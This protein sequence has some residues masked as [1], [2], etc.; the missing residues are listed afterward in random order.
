MTYVLF[1]PKRLLEYLHVCICHW[2]Q[3]IL[4]NGRASIMTRTVSHQDVTVAQEGWHT[5]RT[6][7]Q[8]KNM[9]SNSSTTLLQ[10]MLNQFLD[11]SREWRLYLHELPCDITQCEST[12]H[13]RCQKPNWERRD[14]IIWFIY[15]IYTL[16]KS[17][18][19]TDAF[20][21]TAFSILLIRLFE[22]HRR[23][24][25]VHPY[26]RSMDPGKLRFLLKSL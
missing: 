10:N 9:L 11:D 14:R 5:T 23:V 26:D 7:C 4:V 21:V 24:Q 17:C 16:N 8:T 19:F 25:H 20:I 3:T 15:T 13:R 18:W 6:S 12:C 2:N 1:D 22:V